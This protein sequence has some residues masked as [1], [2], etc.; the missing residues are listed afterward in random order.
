MKFCLSNFKDFKNIL[1]TAEMVLT[2]IKFEADNDG[3]RFRGFDGGKTSFFSVDFSKN[4]FDEYSIE[5]PETITVDSSE[6][7]KVMKRIKNDDDVCVIIDDFALSINVNGKKTFKIN[8]LDSEYDSPNLPYMEFEVSTKVD[9]NDLRD[10]ITDSSL[11][12]DTFT[13]E[14]GNGALVISANGMLGEYK[15]ELLVGDELKEGC[16]SMFRNNLI[17]SFFKL[18]NFSDMVT[19]H[20]GTQFPILL[21]VTD[22]LEEVVVKLLVAPRIEEY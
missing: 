9:F 11:Y 1:I 22:D 17:N 21:E 6:L 14:S 5:K 4:Y 19:M 2:E 18:G 8:A 20:M 10:S 3:L 16:K 7:N 12:L 13:I 15:S